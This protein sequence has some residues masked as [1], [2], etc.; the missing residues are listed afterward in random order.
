MSAPLSHLESRE[1]EITGRAWRIQYV[2]EPERSLCLLSVT[3]HDCPSHRIPEF[4]VMHVVSGV[5]RSFHRV[6][7]PA[8][9]SW[10][11]AGRE[12]YSSE[13]GST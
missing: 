9:G 6:G 1:K 5:T 10:S 2:Q 7:G 11:V 4:V 3:R 12:M 8:Q 13:L